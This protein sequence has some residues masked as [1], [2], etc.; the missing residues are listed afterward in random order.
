[1]AQRRVVVIGAGLAGLVAAAAAREQGARVVLLDRGAM[2]LGSNSAMANG[3]FAGP[4]ASY[5]AADY[6][7]D[8]LEVGRH[9]NRASYLQRVAG[10]VPESYG[11]L[12]RLGVELIQGENYYVVASPQ[13]DVIR[14]VNL[15]RRLSETVRSQPGIERRAGFLVLEIMQEGGR[16][17]GVRGLD[18]QGAEVVLAAEAVVLAGGGAGAVYARNDNQRSTLGQAYLLAAQAGLPLMD[19]EFVQF[20]PIVL[21]EPGLPMVMIYPRYPPGVGLV[22]RQ[23]AD[24]LARHGL[25]DINQAILTMRD[26]F[27]ALLYEES[28][29][30]PVRMDLTRVAA[31][32]WGRYPLGLLSRMR[33]DF[34]NRP[35]AVAPGAHFCM[36]GVEIDAQAQTLL[37]GLFACGEVVWGLHGANRRGGN[38]LCE[39]AVS[40]HLAGR[41]AA[42]FAAAHPDAPPPPASAGSTPGAGEGSREFP[43]RALLAE[44]RDIAW[45][46]AGIGRDEQGLNR[47]LARLEDLEQRI[48]EAQAQAPPAAGAAQNLRAA[49]FTVRAVLTASLARRES[50]GALWRRDYPAQDDAAWQCNSR[51]A[52]DPAGGG[53]TLDHRPA[54]TSS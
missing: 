10:L 30:G 50:R 40:G 12:A 42:A 26:R 22:D 16:A 53:M 46:Q 51:L 18:K 14:G 37:P 38:A 44:V 2:G 4:T 32:H 45:R 27:S 28:L 9:L 5:A 47:G 31:E 34:Q 20:Y 15:M 11:F 19:M 48:N 54:A 39:C 23:G 33:F 6:V 25:E 24:L 8:T 35:V 21:A 3:V 17:A 36:G 29:Q 52:Y 41:G 43:Y 13:P 1:M 7:R 49:L